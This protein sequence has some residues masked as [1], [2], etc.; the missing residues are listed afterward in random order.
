MKKFFESISKIKVNNSENLALFS[1]A[2][3]LLM[4]YSGK[5]SHIGSA[6]SCID[7]VSVIFFNFLKGKKNKLI[8]SKGHAGLSIYSNLFALKLIPKK[9]IT[10]YLKDNSE[11]CG[12]I[13]HKNIPYIDHSTGSLGYGCGIAAGMG[14]SMKFNNINN[15][16]FVILSEGDLNE[17]STW[18]SLMFISHF[19]LNNVIIL[20]DFNKIQSLD[21]TDNTI[22]LDPLSKK[23]KNF[24][25]NVLV[26]HGHNH[27]SL[28]QNLKKS[29]K[30][31]KVSIIICNTTK[32]K[33][34]K[35]MESKIEWH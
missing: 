19:N 6:F 28:L 21:T 30:S 1:R 31:K 25:F 4:A 16:I 20:I 32:G 12:H 14:L 26:S 22:I 9:K 7:I 3:S 33:G 8:L 10:N 17:G 18:E 29:I 5:A 2:C 15:K 35:E 13:I 27:T 23:L 34:V 24:N 11:L